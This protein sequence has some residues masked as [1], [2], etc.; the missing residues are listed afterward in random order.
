MTTMYDLVYDNH[1]HDDFGYGDPR[2]C[3]H[4]PWVK[5]SSDDGMFDAPCGACEHEM[6]TGEEVTSPHRPNDPIVGERMGHPVYL[7]DLPDD[8]IPF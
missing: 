7:S 5:T 8:D 3:P 4:H 2:R 6:E 1:D